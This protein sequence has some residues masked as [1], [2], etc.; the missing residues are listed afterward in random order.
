[1][2]AIPTSIEAYFK[3]A[4]FTATELLII[5]KLMEGE[6]LTLRQLGAKTGK[7]TGV[8]DQ[9]M[10]KLLR[11]EVV[12]R[13][14][15]N[16]SSCYVMMP[17]RSLQQWMAKDM[18]EKRDM[19]L[20]K[21]QNFETF[22]QTLEAEKTRPD[23]EFFEGAEG[24]EQAYQRVLGFG[25][26]ILQYVPVICSADDDPMRE[27][28][29][30]WFR[31]RRQRQIFA[32]IIAHNTVLGRRYQSRDPF[33]YRQTLLV[34]EDQYPFS[35]EKI[36]AGD[37]V[38][39][40]NPLE[41]RACFIHYPEMA[42][43]ERG[44]FEGIWKGEGKG[45]RKDDEEKKNEKEQDEQEEKMSEITEHVTLS[46]E[47]QQ[48]ID[49]S[50][51]HTVSAIIQVLEKQL[52]QADAVPLEVPTTQP[53][54]PLGTRWLSAM[55]E[56]FLSPRSLVSLVMIGIFAGLMSAG[57][58]WYTSRLNFENL[59][60]QAMSIAATGALQI[61]PDDLAQLNVEADWTKPQWA[62][63]V[64]QLEKIRLQN[65]H[66]IYVY[67]FRKDPKDP[68]KLQFVSDSHSINPYANIDDDTTN[69]VDVGHAP[70]T[71][72]A[73]LLQWPGQEYPVPSQEVFLGFNGNAATTSFYEDQW[74]RMLSGYSPIYGKDGKVAAVLAVD[75]EDFFWNQLNYQVF[76]PI[77]TFLIVLL[78]FVLL[79][80]FAHNR[81]LVKEAWY[82]LNMRRTFLV[83][84]AIAEVAAVIILA[85]YVHARSENQR[86]IGERLMSIAT[87]AAEQFDPADLDKL[88]WAKDM[89]TP[90]YQKVYKKLNEIRSA[91]EDIRFA[92]IMRL[93]DKPNYWEFVADADS[94]YFN[95]F[96]MEANFNGV[97]AELGDETIWPGKM[98][99]N[100]DDSFFTVMQHPSYSSGPYV[101]QWGTV[102]SGVAR[103]ENSAYVIGL[104]SSTQ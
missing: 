102:I 80:F 44:L 31:E 43:M 52:A 46:L 93:T 56:F 99:F 48:K 15:I 8:L 45:K 50:K 14:Q 32:R 16:D 101:D 42:A 7:S 76:V 35:F 89:K 21:Y 25:P 62:K 84:L 78:T 100:E 3:E 1:M 53:A 23:M 69:D 66:L 94:N 38:T 74:G 34:N 47:E 30:E 20:R 5:R 73:E 68:T 28:K 33:E 13:Q 85:M 54:I 95:P 92:Y 91:N 36:I 70:D 4:G 104:D 17:L 103:I 79:R 6:G 71:K 37:S 41:K 77:T 67:I 83:G 61:D 39:C 88:H 98:Y 55:R 12:T 26:E 2:N 59:R 81:G 49:T 18:K 10:K 9:A 63:V 86:Q 57:M 29:V 60:Q 11:K 90:E 87:V 19:M 75:F 82:A 96:Y 65:P 72:E 27:F 40:I 58:Y 24:L 51:Q 22:L 64:H 97:N